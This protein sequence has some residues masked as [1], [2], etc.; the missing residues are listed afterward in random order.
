MQNSNG[1]ANDAQIG[2]VGYIPRGD[3]APDELS[4]IS[5]LLLDQRFME[6]DR[7]ISF[8]DMMF[9]APGAGTNSQGMGVNGWSVG[10]GQMG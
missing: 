4:A 6:M 7:I 10:S 3:E 1:N 2:L 8:D 5:H 9:T